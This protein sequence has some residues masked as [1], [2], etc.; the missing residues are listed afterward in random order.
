MDITITSYPKT[1]R[2]NQRPLR[3]ASRSPASPLPFRPWLTRSTSCPLVPDDDRGTDIRHAF[4]SVLPASGQA[5]DPEKSSANATPGQGTRPTFA[6][7]S[8][9]GVT[10]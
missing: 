9:R 2:R 1:P 6:C 7:V 10:L 4:L 8:L 5:E 3:S